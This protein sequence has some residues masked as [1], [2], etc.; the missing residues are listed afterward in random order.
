MSKWPIYATGPG[1]VGGSGGPHIYADVATL[2]G[3]K[4]S[5]R[6]RVFVEAC[7]LEQLIK[8]ASEIR[9]RDIGAYGALHTLQTAIDH[10]AEDLSSKVTGAANKKGID[11]ETAT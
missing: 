2:I 1:P 7:F 10:V 9:G 5:T 4:D 11:F 3:L 8:C 6:A